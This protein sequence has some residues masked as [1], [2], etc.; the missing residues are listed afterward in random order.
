MGTQGLCQVLEYADAGLLCSG[1]PI[2]LESFGRGLFGLI[3]KGSEVF[4]HIIGCSQRLV[5]EESRSEAQPS[6]Q[7]PIPAEIHAYVGAGDAD[8]VLKSP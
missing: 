7:L 8:R 4:L 1:D 5:Q 2:I 3:P 6:M